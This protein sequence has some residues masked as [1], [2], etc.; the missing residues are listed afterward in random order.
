MAPVNPASY[1]L[2]VLPGPAYERVR[3]IS[4][5]CTW[6]ARGEEAQVIA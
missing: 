4:W 1:G 2:H 3:E 5:I 6:S